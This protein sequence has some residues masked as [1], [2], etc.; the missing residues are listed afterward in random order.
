MMI[1]QP[2][3]E[4]NRIISH[5]G[6]I[7]VTAKP[8][9]GKT[10]T[11]VEKIA[12]ILPGLPSYKGVIAISFTNKASDELKKRCKYRC[13][14]TKQSFFGTIDKFYISQVIIPFASHVTGITTDFE[15]IDTVSEGSRFADLSKCEGEL[16][17]TETALLVEGLCEGKIFLEYTGE[18][19]MYLLENVPGSL[20]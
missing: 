6:N 2:T 13:Y 18:T 12:Q 14:D 16:S 3:D 15:I 19:A 17:P 5:T 11:I 20:Y 1:R 4:Q 10:Y 8:G 9:S 7:V